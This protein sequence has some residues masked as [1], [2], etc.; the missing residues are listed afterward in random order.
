[1]KKEIKQKIK[2]YLRQNK[3]G[4]HG[5]PGSYCL[6]LLFEANKNLKPVRV[7]I[8]LRTSNEDEALQRAVIFLQGVYALGGKFSN[9]IYLKAAQA[10][11][12][13]LGE[14][15]KKDDSLQFEDLPLFRFSALVLPP[16]ARVE[17][18]NPSG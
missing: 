11:P 18:N 4:K 2:K 8:G 13:P 17:K 14:A 5:K 15:L 9:K 3:P 16:F 1:M 10:Q 7:E 12:V 6:R